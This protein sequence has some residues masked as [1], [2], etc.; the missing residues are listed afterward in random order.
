MKSWLG[1]GFGAEARDGANPSCAMVAL[2]AGLRLVASFG[3]VVESEDQAALQVVLDGLAAADG[4][5]ALPRLAAV[6][7]S[8]ATTDAN[9]QLFANR[10]PR[11]CSPV[12]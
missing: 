4:A 6:P 2:A 12:R 9:S 3:S 11:S 7:T 10:N 8:R 5:A 1:A